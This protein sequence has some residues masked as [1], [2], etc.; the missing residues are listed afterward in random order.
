M[1]AT[2]FI[3]MAAALLAQ[4]LGL[5]D[6]VAQVISKVLKCPKCLGFWTVLVVL[7]M[8]GC[9]IVIAVGLSLV[10]AYLSIWC[11]LL[12]GVL[13]DLYEMLWQK[14]RKTE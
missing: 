3:A 7:I 10:M 8:E 1:I 13:N 4:H 9:N 2:A 14:T 6:A 12:L 5:S 11:G